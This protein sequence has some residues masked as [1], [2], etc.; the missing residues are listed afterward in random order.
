MF[1]LIKQLLGG[2]NPA[3]ELVQE[4]KAHI[5][6]V[7]TPGEYKAGHVQGS[8]NIP[9]DR[10]Q[11]EMGSLKN[12]EHVVICCAS[13]A[14]SGMATSMLKSHGH[15]SVHNGGPWHRVHQWKNQSK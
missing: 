4:G 15:P 14:R 5:V 11:R 3:A 8:V 13:G 6:D 10:F 7:R 9:L 1:G 12:K 2:K